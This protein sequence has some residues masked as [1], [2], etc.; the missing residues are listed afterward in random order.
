MARQRAAAL[1]ERVEVL[2]KRTEVSQTFANPD[3]TFTLE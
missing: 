1:G 3:G 2:Q